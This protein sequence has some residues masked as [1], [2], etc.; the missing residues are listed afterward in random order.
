MGQ[1]KTLMFFSSILTL[2][3]FLRNGVIKNTSVNNLIRNIFIVLRALKTKGD[4][5]DHN[6]KYFKFMAV[7]TGFCS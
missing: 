5:K 2:F 7:I 6:K 3:N 4:K 1:F